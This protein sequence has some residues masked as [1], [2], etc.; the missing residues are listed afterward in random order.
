M[1]ISESDKALIPPSECDG[2]LYQM[3][4]GQWGFVIEADGKFILRTGGYDNEDEARMGMCDFLEP[5][6][7]EAFVAKMFAE[8]GYVGEDEQGR[9][10]RTLPG[11]GV[12]LIDG[13]E[14]NSRL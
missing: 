5:Y 2:R 11:G 9:L 10:V 8:G 3:P 6:V 13:G 4:S 1:N 7:N 14:G 12:E